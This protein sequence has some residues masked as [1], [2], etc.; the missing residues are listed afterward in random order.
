MLNISSLVSIRIYFFIL[1][2][3]ICFYCSEQTLTTVNSVTYTSCNKTILL[4]CN[5]DKL[6]YDNTSNI[7]IRWKVDGNS[8]FLVNKTY[9]NLSS[10]LFN[11]STSLTGN[12][13]CEAA[14]KF[15]KIKNIIMLQYTSEWFTKEEIEIVISMLSIFIILLWSELITITFKLNKLKRIIYLYA[16]SL[17]I[18]LIMLV[19]QYM[20]SISSVFIFVKVQGIILIQISILIS[21]FVQIHLYKYVENSY[22]I[23]GNLVLQV[24]SY[25]ISCI[26]LILSFVGCYN[27]I[28]IYLFIYKLLFINVLELC[29]L[30]LLFITPLGHNII[31][32]K[33]HVTTDDIESFSI[34]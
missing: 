32:K 17:W 2:I 1:T 31:Y 26:I 12:Y 27:Q 6:I 25:L 10:L 29:N 28:Y 24:I 23:I 34:G 9:Y 21:M 20:I 7:D 30:V 14:S 19:G 16:V 15:N 13:T 3:F 8:I 11:F 18:T 22:L 33:L 4:T 5:L